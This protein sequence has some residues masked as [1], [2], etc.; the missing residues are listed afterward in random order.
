MGNLTVVSTIFEPCIVSNLSVVSILFSNGKWNRC[1]NNFLAFDFWHSIRCFNLFLKCEIE[2]LLQKFFWPWNVGNLFPVLIFFLKWNS[3]R[4]F[5]IF[6]AVQN[7]QSIRCFT[8]VLL[9]NGK[10]NRCFNTFLALYC[11]Q[12]IRRFTSF[13]KWEI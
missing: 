3:H 5:N 1:F 9:S 10:S 2:T 6:L 8:S 7:K 12:S 11:R 13:V 4:C